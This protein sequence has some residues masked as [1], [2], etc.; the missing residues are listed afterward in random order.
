MTYGLFGKM[1]AIDGRGDELAACLL[2]AA[3]ALEPV[4]GCQ[5]YV[6]SRDPRDGDSVWV[7]E[8]WDSEDSHRASLELEAVRNLIA[9][10]RPILQGFGDR[11][12]LEPLGGKGLSRS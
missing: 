1:T 5:L 2:E 3:K 12:E 11:F 9:R 10:A 7:M 4:E 8:A 6:V